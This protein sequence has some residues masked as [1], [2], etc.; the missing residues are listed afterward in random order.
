MSTV[1]DNTQP[2][3]PTPA[4]GPSPAAKRGKEPLEARA[5]PTRPFHE[6]ASRAIERAVEDVKFPVSKGVLATLTGDR[7]IPL[8]NGK[9][10]PLAQVLDRIPATKFHNAR[11]VMDAANLQWE[12]ISRIKGGV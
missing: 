12:A 6:A 8:G 5:M 10:A 9:V 11:E 2:T 3:Q 4:E 7:Q 1:T